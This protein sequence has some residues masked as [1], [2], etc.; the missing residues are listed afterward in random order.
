MPLDWDK[1]PSF[2]LG[3]QKWEE[4]K[5]LVEQADPFHSVLEIGTSAGQTLRL[6][7]HAGQIG[8]K[9]RSIDI[10]PMADTIRDELLA[11]K[12]NVAQFIGDSRD[13]E[14]IAWAR[15]HGPFDLIFIDA[16]HDYDAVKADW[17]NYRDLGRIVAFHD[18]AHE[19][20]GVKDLWR[21]ITADSRYVTRQCVLYNLMGIGLV[22]FSSQKT[23][24][25]A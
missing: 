22:D 5:W 8:V 13:P 19:E 24:I 14:S 10:S 7:A 12:F 25:A 18:I 15:L 20:H 3:Q 16:N 4:I 23:A 11:K 2:P 21:E 9:V 1:L 6:F 17:E